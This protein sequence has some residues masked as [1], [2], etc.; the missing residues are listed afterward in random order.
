MTGEK[1]HLLALCAAAYQGLAETTG[2][3]QDVATGIR[4]A[5]ATWS[6]IAGRYTLAWGPVT[7]CP[8]LSV[9]DANAAFAVRDAEQPERLVVVVRGTNPLCVFDWIFGDLLVTTTVPWGLGGA[10]EN[11]RISLSTAAGLRA[12]LCLRD[13]PTPHP[14]RGPGPVPPRTDDG[15]AAHLEK[16][17]QAWHAWRLRAITRFLLPWIARSGLHTPPFV[18]HGPARG[19]VG[20]TLPAFLRRAVDGGVS[21]VVVVGHSKGGA[22][23]T[24]LAQFLLDTQ[25][26][27]EPGEALWDPLRKTRIHCWS[28]AGPTLGNTA[29]AAW[30]GS[31]MGRRNHRVANTNDI[32]PHAWAYDDLCALADL[33]G[34]TLPPLTPLV[35]RVA[36]SVRNLDYRHV[37]GDDHVFSAPHVAGRPL[38][39]QVVHQHLAAYLADAGITEEIDVQRILGLKG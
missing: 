28:F 39:E 3:D 22:L 4:H 6:P 25:G 15:L 12:L 27:S 24:A 11:A 10:P 19:H 35:R 30:C 31:R 2:N 21:D 34:A 7:W 29:F 13:A 1:A 14:R 32:V 9:F 5:L 16:L 33:Y 18:L 37:E 38:A 26:T 17:H 8:P 36:S 23:A 20:A